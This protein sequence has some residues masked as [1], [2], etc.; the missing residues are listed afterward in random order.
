MVNHINKY[1]DAQ[2]IQAALDAGTLANPYV[3]MTSAGT[4]DYNTLSP[5]PPAPSTMGTWSDDGQG[6]YT[7]QITETDGQYWGDPINIGTLDGIYYQ[8]SLIDMDVLLYGNGET[9]DFWIVKFHN[10][11]LSED[12]GENMFTKGV[13]DNWGA[14]DIMT[15]PDQSNAIVFVN[16]DGVDT[17][18]FQKN[19]EG[20]GQQ[21]SMTT[22][23]PPYPEVSGE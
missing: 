22:I 14:E 11:D 15:D 12:T 19:P 2:A 18:V 23:D 13:P 4:I 3:A 8:S 21:L 5:T 9:D 1:A 6:V 17:F 16:W 7:F 20:A 10:E